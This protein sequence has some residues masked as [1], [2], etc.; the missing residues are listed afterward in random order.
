MQAACGLAQLGKLPRFV[1]QRK[2]NFRFLRERLENLA[3][4]LR[5]PEATPGSDPAWF[6]FP[7]T[8]EE[9]AGTAR[10]DLLRYLD[11]YKIGTRLLFAGNITR[12][13]YMQGR[14]FRCVGA[15]PN[16]DKIM[17]DTFCIGVQPALAPAA[18]EFI[19]EK[20]E[21]YFDF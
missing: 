7:L 14:P 5:L 21:T 18:L 20:L 11:Q 15:L 8:L 3:A 6:G 4:F 2:A 1:E 13:P 9:E 19:A 10:V 17:R 12:Q 16:T